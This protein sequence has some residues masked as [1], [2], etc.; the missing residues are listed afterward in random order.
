[1]S[2]NGNVAE[3]REPVG[4]LSSAFLRAGWWWRLGIIAGAAGVLAAATPV[5]LVAAA[6]H[7]PLRR[8]RDRRR[9]WQVMSVG[10]LAV[11]I[12]WPSQTMYWRA[13]VWVLGFDGLDAA[14][15]VGGSVVAV[16]TGVLIGGLY[17]TVDQRYREGVPVGG[18]IATE[19]RVRAEGA[20]RRRSAT[21]RTLIA[22]GGGVP[23][24]PIIRGVAH[25]AAPSMVTRHGL[26]VGPFLRGDLTRFER[27]GSLVLPLDSAEIR[28]LV[29]IGTTGTGKSEFVWRLV[30]HDVRSRV[31]KGGQLVYLN[32]KQTAPIQSSAIRLSRITAG[33][34]LTVRALIR[35]HSGFDMLRG[36]LTDQ[37]GK[38]LA[39][40]RFGDDYWR[41]V[42]NVLASLVLDLKAATSRPVSS[43]PQLVHSL[44]APTLRQLA[45]EYP[46]A[47]T[48]LESMNTA[49]MWG[50][51]TRYASVA[52]TLQGYLAGIAEGGWSWEDTD[53]AV[54]DLPSGTD[55]QAAASLMRI[56][57]LDLAQ[58]ISSPRRPRGSDGSYLPLTLVLEELS[59]LDDDPIIGRAVLDLME[60]GRGLNVRVI[61]VAQ[62]DLG[63]GDER[64]RAAILG[65]GT[66]TVFRVPARAEK[67][68]GLAGTYRRTESSAAYS[69]WITSGHDVGS[70]RDQHSFRVHPDELR[71]LGL[72]ELW[73][74]HQGQAGK[75]YALQAPSYFDRTPAAEDLM[76]ALYAAE[77]PAALA[78]QPARAEMPAKERE[79]VDGRV[80]LVAVD[81]EPTVTQPGRLRWQQEDNGK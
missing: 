10:A 36:S 76:A 39:I 4:L 35:D 59:A 28:H 74:I 52:L 22:Y 18:D 61:V 33:R 72:G 38:L 63:L 9:G 66:L 12:L 51:L 30:E 25:L 2:G 27:R 80:G 26:V 6:T 55:R 56:M 75:A 79:P 24:N 16:A 32:A 37:R 67:L 49:G 29:V 44:N 17:F 7:L 53:V 20:R 47:E 42:S 77:T 65:S 23:D 34:D 70:Q 69:G 14:A 60:R 3:S 41:H 48:L 71:Q 45:K 62:D 5:V 54:C 21:A 58:Y 50:A 1:M 46:D 68:A 15:I 78:Y 73:V 81:D 40:E 57:L 31:A 64:A 13:W 19:A 8:L 11:L 43:L